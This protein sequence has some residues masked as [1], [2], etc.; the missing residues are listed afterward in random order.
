[1]FKIS[2]SSLNLFVECP[3]CFWLYLNREIKRPGAPVASI[4][5]GIDRA[6]KE[7]LNE[8]RA[9]N[10]LPPF[11]KDKLPGKLMVNFPKRGWLEY[12]DKK[13]NAKLGGFLDECIEFED[14]HYAVMD[15]K[16]R[17]SIP[18]AVHQA[19]Q[20]QMD[21]YT[22]LLEENGFPTKKNAYLVYYIPKKITYGLDFQFEILLKEIKTD[23]QRAKEI[24]SNGVVCLSGPIPPLQ[25][26]CGF[27][28][29]L[30]TAKIT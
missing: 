21:V 17:G 10:E 29:W 3:R 6:I 18:E 28:K 14:K 16:T 25:D 2:P 26:N 23:P 30:D 19:Y 27:C 7:Y 12:T 1:M 15:H 5:S 13:L 4:T 24:F 11:L 8:F 9:K 22:L 20:L